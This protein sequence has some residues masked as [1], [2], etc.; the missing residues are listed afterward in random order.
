MFRDCA[1]FRILTHFLDND[2]MSLLGF[3]QAWVKNAMSS[4]VMDG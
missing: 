4:R 2:N 1:V 3:Y